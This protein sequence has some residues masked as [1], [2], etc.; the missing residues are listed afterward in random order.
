MTETSPI[1]SPPRRSDAT[2]S[3]ILAAAR[4]QFA[5]SGYQA[6]TIR[7]IA[8]AAGIDPA[9]VMRYFGNKEKLFAAAA[10]FDLRLP[11]LS[12]MPRKDVGAALVEHFLNRWEDDETLM[13]LLR[14]GVTNEAAAARLQEI[15]A[16]QMAPLIAKLSGEPR[17]AAAGRA[18]L[19]ASQ[20]LGL[21]LCR[22]VLKLQPVVG[23]KRADIVRHVG[24]TVQAYLYDK[25]D[26]N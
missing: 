22:Y 17:A 14:T 26:D 25:W 6:A 1:P 23:L 15:F 19:I 7:A 4:E 9:M 10:E 21:A 18:G 13:A 8:T 5:A 24:V 16:T 12:D 11:D 3:A 2:K 20:I